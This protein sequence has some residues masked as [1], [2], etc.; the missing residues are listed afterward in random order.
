MPFK[1]VFPHGNMGV[2]LFRHRPGKLAAHFGQAGFFK[3]QVRLHYGRNP[4]KPQFLHEPVL[5]KPVVPLNPAFRLRAVR[6]Y[7]LLLEKPAVRVFAAPPVIVI[8]Q[9]DGLR[10]SNHL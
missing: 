5:V 6:R 1:P 7:R 9:H 8:R 4:C 3:K 10:S 2:L